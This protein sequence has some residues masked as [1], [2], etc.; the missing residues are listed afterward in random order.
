MGVLISTDWTSVDTDNIEYFFGAMREQ[1]GESLAEV[2]DRRFEGRMQATLVQLWS[3]PQL[4]REWLRDLAEVAKEAEHRL[5]QGVSKL[6]LGNGA[7]RYAW[8]WYEDEFDGDAVA[9]ISEVL[10]GAENVSSA[11]FDLIDTMIGGV[12]SQIGG[13]HV[14]D[15]ADGF[16]E[17]AQ[18]YEDV[19][20][21]WQRFLEDGRAGAGT[22]VTALEITRDVSFTVA[23]AIATG[24]ATGALGVT[25]TLGRAAVGAGVAMAG[26]GVQA[27]ATGA[28]HVLAGTTDDFEV[29]EEV[30]A[31]IKSGAGGFAGGVVS[32][33]TGKLTEKLG[34]P[35]AAR[36]SPYLGEQASAWSTFVLRHT[37]EQTAGS[38]VQTIAGL[39][40]D[41]A[42][43]KRF[44]STDD[45]LDYLSDEFVANQWQNMIGGV[46]GDAVQVESGT[47]DTDALPRL[48]VAA[49]D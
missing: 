38:V 23:T 35:L 8:Q 44:D 6:E 33:W 31:T 34:G 49:F 7:L 21:R 39:G 47:I 17:V 4:Q 14:A 1:V 40:I 27:A 25:S 9:Y 29:S 32:G 28:G 5:E 18:Y 22:A 43:G 26:R 36:L 11:E 3:D 46:L 45:L 37:M 12:R 24:G 42:A 10:G 2:A 41:T 16:I 20:H 48:F 13:D 19:E 15:A 30:V